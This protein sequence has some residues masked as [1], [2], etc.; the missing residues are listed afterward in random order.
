MIEIS[1]KINII[2][3]RY[4]CGI[5]IHVKICIILETPAQNKT[6]YLLT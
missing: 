1:F 5:G 3:V 6:I 2:F 4:L